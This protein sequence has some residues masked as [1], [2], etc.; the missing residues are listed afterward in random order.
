MKLDLPIDTF[1][2]I[3]N[4]Y[5]NETVYFDAIVLWFIRKLLYII[6][7]GMN[8]KKEGLESKNKKLISKLSI[9]G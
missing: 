5:K 1:K 2:M 6:I 4:I 7:L 8:P 9:S 3:P